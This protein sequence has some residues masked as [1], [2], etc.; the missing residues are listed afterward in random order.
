MSHGHKALQETNI[1]NIS[2]NAALPC[3]FLARNKDN[4]L[5]L[6]D[7]L[8]FNVFFTAIVHE[9]DMRDNRQIEILSLSLT[10]LVMYG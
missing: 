8:S 2:Q 1:A 4:Y 7:K 9:I 6:K 3:V 5:S 10:K